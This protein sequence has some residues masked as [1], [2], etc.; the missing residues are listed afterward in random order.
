MSKWLIIFRQSFTHD[1]G[2]AFQ[3]LCPANIGKAMC[4]EV[5]GWLF[6]QRLAKTSSFEASPTNLKSRQPMHTDGAVVTP[7]LVRF[8]D[9]T[10]LGRASGWMGG[11]IGDW[12]AHLQNQ[13]LAISWFMDLKES[14][15]TERKKEKFPLNIT[16]IS[17]IFTISL[18]HRNKA[19]FIKRGNIKGE[20]LTFRLHFVR[21]TGKNKKSLYLSFEVKVSDLNWRNILLPW[22]SVLF[23]L[24][25]LFW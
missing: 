18:S 22:T 25:R 10:S 24:Y 9:L 23:F 2:L 4:D 6:G 8:H 15:K 5:Y 21:Q 16:S 13:M 1:D 11:W 3:E 12:L 17:Y 20:F 14:P 7:S 19:H